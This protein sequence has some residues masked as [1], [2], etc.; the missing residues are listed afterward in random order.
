[1]VRRQMGVVLAAV[2]TAASLACGEKRP[3][4]VAPTPPPPPPPK[5]VEARPLEGVVLDWPPALESVPIAEALQETAPPEPPRPPA[6]R[7]RVPDVAPPPPPPV[8]D[9]PRLT[10]PET[11]DAAVATRQVRESLT[12]AR[13]ALAVL[14]YEQLGPDA[15]SQ[16]ETVVQLIQQAEDALRT[17]DFVFALKVADKAETLARR[18]SGQA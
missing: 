4:L 13:R 14:R 5:L 11:P 3:V 9:P 8:A 10:T 2:L 1:M 18:L 6:E 17:R 15:R 16:Y 12:R 7:E